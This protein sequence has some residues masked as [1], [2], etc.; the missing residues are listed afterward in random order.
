MSAP[1]PITSVPELFAH[2]LAMEREARERYLEF[3]EHLTD[4]GDYE[5]ADLFVDLARHERD[6]AKRLQERSAGMDLP[7]I[8]PSQYAWLD[9]GAL[10]PESAAHD[11]IW[12][13]M[14]PYHALRIALDA[15]L[16]A[17]A[18]FQAVASADVGA[19]VKALA[20]EMAREEQEHVEWVQAALERESA[21]YP[22][23][24]TV[25]Q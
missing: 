7:R 3:A 22:D 5:V 8:D 25:S 10:A 20:A 14:R 4:R 2:A 23:W 16:R 9:R 12:H 18:F 6:H 17:R 15:E 21:P 19:D 11:L 24:D 13:F 1:R